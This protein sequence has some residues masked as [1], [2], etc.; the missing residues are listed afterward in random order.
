MPVRP[1]TQVPLSNYV[2]LNLTDTHKF[3]AENDQ[4]FRNACESAKI[5][6]TKL[7]ARKWKQKRGKAYRVYEEEKKQL[8]EMETQT[9]VA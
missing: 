5:Q 6:P 4:T 3:F 9:V 8:K 7:Q 1:H 2:S